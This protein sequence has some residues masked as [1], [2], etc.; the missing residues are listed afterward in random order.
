MIAEATRPMPGAAKALVP[1]N[2]I[3]IALG[4]DGLPGSADMVKVEAP[5]MIVAGISR[6]GTP[7]SRNSAIAIGH[8]TK[9]A[10]KTET[11]P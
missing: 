10:T 2:G 11:P 8:S 9:K 3:G 5:S 7:A 1:K 6:R 4:I